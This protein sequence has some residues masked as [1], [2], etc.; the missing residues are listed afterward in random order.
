MNNKYEQRTEASIFVNGLNVVDVLIGIDLDL[1][2]IANNF[3]DFVLLF[4]GK[5]IH[6]IQTNIQQSSV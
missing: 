5:P 3:D 4:V 6:F 2:G 1:S